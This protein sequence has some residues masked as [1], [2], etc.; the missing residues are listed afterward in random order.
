LFDAIYY[1]NKKDT[2]DISKQILKYGED[3]G[4]KFTLKY[5]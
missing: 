4:V 5:E 2:E 1:N 3:R